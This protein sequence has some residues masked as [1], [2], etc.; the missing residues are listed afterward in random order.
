M[1]KS[2]IL[3]LLTLLF[4]CSSTSVPYTYKSYEE[5]VSS[6]KT[7]KEAYP[8]LIKIETAQEKY[9]LPSPDCNGFTYHTH[10]SLIS[11]KSHY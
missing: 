1:E 11:N 6:F 7:L 10:L 3:L 5:I 2:S 9:N 4:L 8:S